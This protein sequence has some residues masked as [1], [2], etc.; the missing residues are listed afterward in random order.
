[1]MNKGMDLPGIIHEYSPQ[2]SAP[3]SLTSYPLWTHPQKFSQ[4]PYQTL[5]LS[6]MKIGRHE[7]FSNFLETY[8]KDRIKC[9]R[10]DEKKVV[11]KLNGQIHELHP[12]KLIRSLFGPGDTLLDNQDHICFTIGGVD[13]V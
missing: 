12:Q 5:F 7:K 13:S 4:D 2:R 3:S 6:F 11:L 8:S 9:L 10:I 1:M